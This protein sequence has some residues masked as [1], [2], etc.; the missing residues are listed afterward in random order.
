MTDV[1]RHS[2]SLDIDTYNVCDRS[3]PHHP[4]G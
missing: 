2:D 4:F 1:L 3:C